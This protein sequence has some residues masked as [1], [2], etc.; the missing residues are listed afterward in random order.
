MPIFIPNHFCILIFISIRIL[1]L[2]SLNI[3]L[4]LFLMIIRM[5]IRMITLHTPITLITGKLMKI[6]I[7]SFTTIPILTNMD[8]I[9]IMNIIRFMPTMMV[10]R[11]ITT[12]IFPITGMGMCTSER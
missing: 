11:I 1:F 3:R 9:T 6:N 2:W 4:I 8:M 10:I 5:N 7:M 12:N